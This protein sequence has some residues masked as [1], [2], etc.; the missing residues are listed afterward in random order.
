MWNETWS[1]HAAIQLSVPKCYVLMG[2]GTEKT[3][4]FIL[5]EI[6]FLQKFSFTMRRE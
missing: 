6:L 5:S 3:G 1:W 2:F 4:G